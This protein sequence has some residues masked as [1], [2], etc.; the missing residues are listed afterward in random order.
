VRYALRGPSS[1]RRSPRC[2]RPSGGHPVL[3]IHPMPGRADTSSRSPNV[4]NQYPQPS[5]LGDRTPA[6][7]SFTGPKLSRNASPPRF[8]PRPP[9]VAY[10][11]REWTPSVIQAPLPPGPRPPQ[12]GAGRHGRKATR[13]PMVRRSP[14]AS[15]FGLSLL[16]PL[17]TPKFLVRSCQDYWYRRA[18]IQRGDSGV[19][20]LQPG[21]L[22]GARGAGGEPD[23]AV[24]IERSPCH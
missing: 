24:S 9:S 16:H 3:V 17:T 15:A 20:T 7:I 21:T 5:L 14:R 10:H 13:R 1:P 4:A 6:T 19:A 22:R 8:L 2:G 23:R 12:R 11:P 18:R